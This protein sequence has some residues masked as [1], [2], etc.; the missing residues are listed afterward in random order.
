MGPTSC[1]VRMHL[2]CRRS[3]AAALAV[4][5]FVSAPLPAQKPSASDKKALKDFTAKVKQYLAMEKALPADKMKPSKDIAALEQERTTLR[6][7]VKAARPNARQGDLFTPAAAAAFRTLLAQTMAR[8][9]GAKVR[10]SLAHAEPGAPSNLTVNSVYPDLRGQPIQSVPPTLLMNL[11]VLPKGI[12]Y[13]IAGKTLA[14]RDANAN[15]VVDLLPDA[16]P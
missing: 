5:L 14:L 8:P 13:R 6:E 9:E 2:P 11:P 10:A 4:L 16:L 12:E 7:A 15:L 1:T 3:C